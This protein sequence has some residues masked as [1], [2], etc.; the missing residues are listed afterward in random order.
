MTTAT[1]T[2]SKTAVTP[3][4][5]QSLAQELERQSKTKRDI[6]VPGKNFKLATQD[7]LI[8]GLSGTFP[9]DGTRDKTVV[10]AIDLGGVAGQ[11]SYGVNRIAHEQL[12]EKTNIPRS[13]YQRCLASAPALLTENV[14]HWLSTNG[15][16]GKNYLVRT[17]DDRV[18]AFLSNRYRALDN[19]DLFYEAMR[20]AKEIG[21]VATRVD[22]T[23]ERFYLRLLAPDFTERVNFPGGA[24]GFARPID[25]DDLIPGVVVSNSEVGRG[26]LSVNPFIFNGACSNGA[27]LDTK[28]FQVHI[29]RTL[30]V[31]YLTSETIAAEDTSIW[32]KV[33]DLIK[34]TFDKEQFSKMV[35]QFQNAAGQVLDEPTVAVDAV[36][37]HY[38]L[39]D[40]DKQAILNELIAPKT[41]END[42]GRTVYGLLQAITAR[43]HSFENY[44]EAREYEKIGGDFLTRAPALVAVR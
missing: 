29:G 27:W 36:V 38:G 1:A 44:D 13:Y 21:A 43:S 7:T 37:K 5:I 4:A 34:A 19:I 23:E 22:L 12:G 3:E 2:F 24:H 41:R 14:N 28:L 18:R 17:L 10:A 42:P 39:S 25:G 26:G 33:R 8:E 16:A 9:A 40:D 15:E 32:L 30:D 11:V 35:A 31:G 20:I 6:V